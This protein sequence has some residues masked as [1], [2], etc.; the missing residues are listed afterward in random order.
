M[1]AVLVVDDDAQL[2]HVVVTELEKR[3]Y[4]VLSASSPDEAKGFLTTADVDVLLTDLRLEAAEDG[5]DLLTTVRDHG[6]EARTILM[7]G[8]ATARDYQAAIELGAVRVLCKP[9]TVDELVQAIEHAVDCETGFRGSVHGLSL[10]DML[11]M[12]HYARRSIVLMIEGPRSGRIEV[13][14][15]E[16]IHARHDTSSGTTALKAL[17]R[18]SSGAIRTAPFTVTVER[19]IAVPFQALLLDTLRELDEEDPNAAPFDPLEGLSSGEGFGELDDA[20]LAGPVEMSGQQGPTADGRAVRAERLRAHLAQALPQVAVVLLTEDQPEE[21][22]LLDAVRHLHES[23]SRLGGDCLQLELV[24]PHLGLAVFATPT[25]GLWVAAH[26]ALAGRLGPQRF[27][28]AMSRLAAL[29][30]AEW[31]ASTP[32]T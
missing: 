29:L 32:D 23:A 21:D 12:F 10:I 2:R 14:E 13:L 31:S 8:Y 3:G 26:V 25:P 20:A 17:L 7:S 9:F 1:T 24:S 27:R 5:I 16:I 18:E 22:P 30:H 4:D 19:S 28:S 11:Q 15:G 6:L